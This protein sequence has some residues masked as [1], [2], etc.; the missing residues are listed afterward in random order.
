M[1]RREF[2][3][4]FA[5]SAATWP[6]VVRAQQGYL[7]VIG[8]LSGRSPDEA[9][10]VL[11][12]FHRGLAETGYIESKNIR[13]E[14]RWAEGR[15]E[16]LPAL[17]AELVKRRVAVIAATGG[18]VAGLAAKTATATIPVVFSSAGDAVKLG[19]VESLNRPGANVTGVNLVFGALG[20]KRLAL[21]REVIPDARSVA[22][23]VNPKY[24]SAADEV[25]DIR[26]AARALRVN[27]QVLEISD[28]EALV[29]A[30]AAL[31]AHGAEGLLVTD[32]PFLQGL[33]NQIVTLAE[34]HA[35]PAVYFSRDFAEAGGL[36][37]H[38]GSIIE[39]YRQVGVYVGKILQGANPAYLPVLQPTA[40][41][42]IINLKTAKALGLTIPPTLLARADEV[43][44]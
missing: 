33:R 27:A 44:E 5:A 36:I 3:A 32:D 2:I 8:F 13:V 29:P 39:A 43:I 42:L 21:L 26:A 30:F 40:F 17:A 35:V 16:K 28:Q 14:Y 24:P 12:A 10:S 11:A 9:A 7:P 31:S 19:L 1:R 4:L 25:D 38:G 34:R 6:L 37:S 20:A 15:Y 18:S 41:D 23:L 22:I